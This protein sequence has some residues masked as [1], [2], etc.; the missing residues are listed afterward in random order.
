MFALAMPDIYPLHGEMAKAST[1][2]ACFFSFTNLFILTFNTAIWK[3]MLV[4]LPLL[5]WF[6]GKSLH[7]ESELGHHRSKPKSLKVGPSRYSVN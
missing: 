6:G 2:P 4:I 1:N 7:Y 3:S 5:W